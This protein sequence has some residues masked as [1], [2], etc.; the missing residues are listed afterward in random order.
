MSLMTNFVTN[1]AVV[2]KVKQKVE[3]LW[4]HMQ[5]MQDVHNKS[6]SKAEVDKRK[7]SAIKL[8]MSL[9]GVTEPY[10]KKQRTDFGT[11]KTLTCH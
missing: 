3:L 10:T 7:V 5:K 4:G 2:L 6:K 8:R 1:C 9:W 11:R